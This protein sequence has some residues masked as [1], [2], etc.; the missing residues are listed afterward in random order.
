MGATTTS[1]ARFIQLLEK[2]IMGGKMNITV[3]FFRVVGGEDFR[4]I[5]GDL[6]NFQKIM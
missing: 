3:V 1:I 5:R 6:W 4:G 2:A